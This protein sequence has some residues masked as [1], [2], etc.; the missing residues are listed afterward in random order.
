MSTL[1]K[2]ET[3][4][5]LHHHAIAEAALRTTRMNLFIGPS[6][7]GKSTLARDLA[8][9]ISGKEPVVVYCAPCTDIT[10]IFGR[11][12]L[13]G[14]E[15]RFCPGPLE[16]ALR[17]G[18]TLV[19]EEFALLPLE[20]KVTLTGLRCGESQITNCMSGDLIPIPESFRCICTGTPE[21]M[22]TSCRRNGEAVRALLSDFVIVEFPALNDSMIREFLRHHFPKASKKRVNR[23]VELFAR[24]RAVEE[25]GDDSQPELNFRAARNL[26]RILEN[27]DLDEH[28]AV[29]CT[30]VSQFVVDR[31]S[32]NA[33]KLK[34]QISG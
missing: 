5:K 14:D 19:F 33:Q 2:S 23:V 17:D 18:R 29:A 13:V 8:V 9:T 24:Y 25:R 3:L 6:G 11:W 32:L 15:S 30:M 16:V 31:D 12:T 7:S 22:E 21:S 10:E 34:L 28:D 26:M 27:T 20:V 1:R 4:V